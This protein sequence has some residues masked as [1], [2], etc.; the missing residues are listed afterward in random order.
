MLFFNFLS[1]QGKVAFIYKIKS[2]TIRDQIASK[3]K[4]EGVWF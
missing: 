3:Q 1:E 2:S 4:K